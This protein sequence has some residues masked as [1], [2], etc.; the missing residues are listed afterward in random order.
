MMRL[1]T[2][3]GFILWPAI[4]L[5]AFG[6]LMIY[7]STSVVT[8]VMERRH[9]PEFYFLKKHLMAIVV[10][11]I[12]LIAAYRVNPML[13]KKAAIPMLV[14]SLVLLLLV[15]VPGIGVKAG[16]AR[17]WIRLW[18]TVFQ[19]S[20]L[21]KLSMV[22]FLARFLSMREY[23]GR[24]LAY[25]L[26]P[27]SVMAAFQLVFLGQPDFG[28]ALS[29]GMLTMGMLYLAGAR[30]VYIIAM[31][32]IATPFVVKLA[33]VSY[34]FK[35][36]TTFLDPWKY[37]DGAGHQLVQS[38]IA[39]GS[40]G[41]T[42]VGLGN[43]RQKL[44]FLPEVHTDFIFSLIGEELGFMAAFLVVA[45]F[46]VI[47]FRGVM[48]ARRMQDKFMSNLAFGLSMM[49]AMQSIVNFCVVTGMLPTKGLPLPFL[50]YGGSSLLI[51]MTAVGILL[52]LSRR[53]DFQTL[54]LMDK[55]EILKERMRL[56]KAKFSVSRR[57]AP[58]AGA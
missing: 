3:D 21:V 11:I 55:E 33:M 32:L 6:V 37:Q 31:I 15:Y 41:L 51:N 54:P 34:R 22:I 16:G 36:I 39:L 30:A 40:G 10:S 45:A 20:E 42:G 17:R 18:P 28:A 50:S 12:A 26:I 52:N 29:L 23:E 4:A 53:D 38:F 58:G 7:S 48:I 43:S 19:P 5:A 8:P 56:K 47:F 13:L 24:K 1:R 44:D 25:F 2:Y 46:A 49:L 35:R 57:R 9:L 27:V 14:F